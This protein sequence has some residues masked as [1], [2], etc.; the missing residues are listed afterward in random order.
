MG[1]PCAAPI[2]G[3]GKELL[4]VS[5][6]ERP[7]NLLQH[8]LCRLSRTGPFSPKTPDNNHEGS[9]LKSS[10]ALKGRWASNSL[11]WAHKAVM[12]PSNRGM[13]EPESFDESFGA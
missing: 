8:L 11:F 9:S 3:S 7:S 1:F 4:V 6:S 5:F 2:R 13:F 10:V 12:N